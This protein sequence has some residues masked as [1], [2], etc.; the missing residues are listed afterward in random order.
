MGPRVF[1]FFV[2]IIHYKQYISGMD[3]AC[4]QTKV[5]DTVDGMF[6]VYPEY[7]GGTSLSTNIRPRGQ[8]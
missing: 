2:H 4:G 6:V 7:T 8:F 3:A 5:N 1:F